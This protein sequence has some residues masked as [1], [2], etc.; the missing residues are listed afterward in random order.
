MTGP[1][2][3][4]RSLAGPIYVPNLLFSI[5][6]GAAIPV[7]ALLALELGASPA[8]AGLVVALRGL[9]TMLFDLPAGV[10]VARIGEKRAMVVSGLALTLIALGIW[11]G[12]PLW[13]YSLLV[14]LMGA[15]GA[16]WLLARMAYAAGSSP[17][18]HRGRVMAMI[19]GVTRIGLLAGPLIGSLVITRWGI[20]DAFLVLASL[21]L[22]ATIALVL[23]RPPASEP[24]TVTAVS[25][26]LAQV[27]HQNRDTLLTAGSV[28]VVAQV[29]RSSREALIPLWGDHIG[30][31]AESIALLFA[32]S[33]AIESII[34]YPVGMLM[35]RKGRKWTAIPTIAML[36]VGVA[37]VPLT[38][39][40]VS[41][42]AVALL[43]GLANG[44]GSGMNMTLGSD[45]APPSDR[46]YF[47]AIWRL[48]SDAGNAGGPL[49][50]AAVTSAATLGA[51]AVAVGGVGLAGLIV[52]VRFVPETLVR[53]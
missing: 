41:L 45:L 43:M 5:G 49:L 53:P 17:P 26:G 13:A 42:A 12:P 51:A 36:S 29:L 30:L 31:A 20:G 52:L 6:Q 25:V 8:V 10:L 3:R 50:V 34:F 2:F 4:V 40:F 32:I 39:D 15:A 1:T 47:L 14:A 21:A 22:L 48:I 24:E 7:V 35:D 11:A 9:G 19:G 38:S 28:A 44:L 46:S 23:S 16:V 33:A 27:A 37:L 18:G